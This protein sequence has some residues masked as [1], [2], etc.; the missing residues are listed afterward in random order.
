MC[1]RKVQTTTNTK[2]QKKKSINFTKILFLFFIFAA[3]A[4]C[5]W[6][7]LQQKRR[8]L[9][10]KHCSP[11]DNSAFFG[12]MNDVGRSELDRFMNRLQTIVKPEGTEIKLKPLIMETCA[13]LFFSYMC[14]TRF[15]FED[16]RF[17]SMVRCFDEIFWEI[18]Q[19][20]AVDFL[21]WLSPFYTSHMK[22][23][24]SWAK[25][26]REYILD[27]VIDDRVA[28]LHERSEDDDDFT[29]AL[30]RSLSKEQNVTK[31]TII[32]MLEDFLGGHSAI[33]EF[34]CAL[35]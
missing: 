17:K 14:S 7:T 26:I 24:E 8:N 15:E 22:K 21:P 18:N 28:T 1:H 4:L 33:G 31:D 10:R 27:Q 20:Y 2:Q 32:F 34:V 9:A 12:R 25:T 6:S 35:K 29:D 19:G 11:R 30:L 5:D 13:N 3:L 23:L 16:A